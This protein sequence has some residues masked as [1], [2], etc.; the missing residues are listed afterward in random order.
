MI[1]K[2]LNKITYSN[3]IRFEDLLFVRFQGFRVS[4]TK[5]ALNDMLKN[6]LDLTDI[7]QVLEKGRTSPRKRKKN[8]IE[9]WLDK[10]GKIIEVVVAMDYNETLRKKEWVLIHCG[11]F[12]K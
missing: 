7:K 8:T 5:S 9:K 3:D 2:D 1:S 4:V 12:S 6:N 11:V 10:K